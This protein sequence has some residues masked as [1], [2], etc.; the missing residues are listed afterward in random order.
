VAAL[1]ILYGLV[2]RTRGAVLRV[3]VLALMVLALANPSA[4]REERE[5]LADVVAV[6]VDRS[7]SQKIAGR[8]ELS[9]DA[10]IKLTAAIAERSNVELRVSETDPGAD[11]T[12]LFEALNTLIADVPPERISGALM[13]TDGQVH[14]VPGDAGDFLGGAPLHVL[15]SGRPDEIDRRISLIRAPRYGIVGESQTVT[16]KVV[17]GTG[18]NEA[19]PGR[20]PA[21]VVLSVDGKTVEEVEII[22][23]DEVSLDFTIDHGGVNV[24]ELEAEAR[25]NE[26][27][28]ENN[29]VVFTARGIRDRLRVLLI[30]GEPH[31]GERT[32]R[33]LLKAD[34]S[35]DLVHFTILRPPE[36]QDGTPIDELSLIAFP[37]RELFS[38]K[39]NEFDLIIFDRYQRRGVLPLIYLD[40]VVE[41]VRR[42]GAVLAAAGPA[43]ATQRSISR[44]P[45]SMVLPALPT[46]DVIAEPYRAQIT[47]L[48]RRHPVTR[49]LPGG[50]SD[51]AEPSWGRWF[52]LVDAEIEAGDVVMN[53][54]AERPLMVLNREGEGR[55]ALLL[56]DQ[57]W[58]WA[59]RFEGG[60][61][62]A[63]LLRRLAHWLMKE[64]ELEEESL[65]ADLTGNQLS[66][67]RHS[68]G[69]AVAPVTVTAPD[70]V[71]TSVTLTEQSPGV[72]QAATDAPMPG[73][74]RLRSGEL[75]AVAAAG[76][77]RSREL[78]DVIATQSLLEPVSDAT[79]GGIYWTGAESATSASLPAVRLVRAGRRASGSDWLGLRRREAYVV[80][81]S[82]TYPLMSG[83][84]AA[85][86]ILAAMGMAWYREGR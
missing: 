8:E 13:I 43:F 73:V 60:G 54:P 24:I 41:Y 68:I 29:H 78:D 82:S 69:E 26:L 32:W 62:Q 84:I 85:A 46:G 40:N 63:E 10:R 49:Q 75:N 12:R 52:R 81:G 3:L 53:G 6:V 5:P 20:R 83:L 51:S 11:E 55:V 23:G 22:P 7:A 44:S 28:L 39:L 58:L 34:S 64:P 70:G 9:E 21:R 66:I 86:I 30:S 67:T 77:L 25:D 16:F 36:K 71:E 19:A 4:I 48:G 47:E 18:G 37:T 2:R 74:Y 33:N 45:L 31:P 65:S 59:R 14:D 56:S 61:P 27:S 80:T 15:L 50:G 1:P 17:D 76:A 79:G 57:V 38:V 72:W 35:V 42:G